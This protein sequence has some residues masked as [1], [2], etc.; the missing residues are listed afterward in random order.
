MAGGN[1]APDVKVK[2]D[3]LSF[4][5]KIA[6]AIQRGT[7]VNVNAGG[8]ALNAGDVTAERF[9]G[10]AEEA[11][12]AAEAVA[13]GTVKIRVRRRGIFKMT[14]AT[15]S[16]SPSLVGDMVYVDTAPSVSVNGLV[17]IAANVTNHILVGMI[18]KHGT[19]AE[20]LAGD[21][22]TEVWVDILGAMNGAYGATFTTTADLASASNGKGATLIGYEDDGTFSA[23]TNVEEALQEISQHLQSAQSIIQLPVQ[24][25]CNASGDPLVIYANSDVA[26]PM[27]SSTAEG[28]GLR[29]N[30][31][32]TFTAA[33]TT[34]MLPHK[35]DPAEDVIF[36]ALVAKS[37]ATNNAGNTTTLTVGATNA[38]AAALYDADTNFG[39]VT[40]ALVPDATAKT[41][42]HLTRT[43]A[44]ADVVNAT[45][46]ALVL[47]VAPTNGT[48][49]TDDLFVFAMWLEYTPKFLTA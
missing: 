25:F 2:G 38:V 40:G 7:M 8:Y 30:N 20:A 34:V 39:G 44:A 22:S 46:T 13:N 31:K 11:I 36:H 10:M 47:T 12:T 33:V 9:V 27:L 16:T 32:S 6:V 1:K 41:I 19:D 23:Q 48:L 43:L 26:T 21:N 17:D 28:Y 29:W 37:G 14:L 5:T 49:D 18:V 4:P 15:T 45:D 35:L 3:I 24:A 42:T